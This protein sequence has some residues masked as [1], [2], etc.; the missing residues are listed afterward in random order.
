MTQGLELLV[1]RVYR[2]LALVFMLLGPSTSG[3]RALWQGREKRKYEDFEL[4][5]VDT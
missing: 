3:H 4:W 2:E 1:G 5:K